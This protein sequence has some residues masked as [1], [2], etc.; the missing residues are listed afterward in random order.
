MKIIIKKILLL[1]FGLTDRMRIRLRSVAGEYCLQK[2]QNK[3]IGC[4]ASGWMELYHSNRIVLGSNVHFGYGCFLQGEGGIEVKDHTHI[5]RNVV[6]HTSNHNIDGKYV[7]YDE[8]KTLKPV[9]IGRGCW[10][11]MNVIVV[12]GVTIGDGAVIGMGTVVSKDVAPGEILVGAPAR[13]VGERNMETF[14][15]LL[16]Q[17]KVWGKGKPL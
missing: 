17:K 10:I 7:P 9:S 1:L 4:S 8:T 15:D 6:I 16:G 13:T 2:I 14:R 5:S 12:P 11:G 3:G